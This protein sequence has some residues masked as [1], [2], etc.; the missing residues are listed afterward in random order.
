MYL[1]VSHECGTM[2]PCLY[3]ALRSHGNENKF[4]WE[5]SPDGDGFLPLVS[6][7]GLLEQRP[8][9]KVTARRLNECAEALGELYS[10]EW[11]KSHGYIRQQKPMCW[12]G[13]ARFAPTE[14]FRRVA[15]AT[16]S[17]LAP[18]NGAEGTERVILSLNLSA[19]EEPARPVAM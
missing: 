13:P 12:V 5:P 9:A 4:Y 19:S 17:L 2:G 7:C 16:T 3:T 6:L 11:C 10:P 15:A 14:P 8:E 18:V 1:G